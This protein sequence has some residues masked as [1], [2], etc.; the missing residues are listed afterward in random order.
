MTSMSQKLGAAVIAACSSHDRNCLRW[1]EN[2]RLS[3][4]G[5]PP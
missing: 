5:S 4:E 3:S 2:M 1:H